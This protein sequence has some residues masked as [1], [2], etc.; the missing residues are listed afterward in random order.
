LAATGAAFF[1][2]EAF[3]TFVSTCFDFS[4]DL[5]STLLASPIIGV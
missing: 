2:K 1:F 3:S 5:A 4:T